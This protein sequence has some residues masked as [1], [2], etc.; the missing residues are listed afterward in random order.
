[1]IRYRT[2]RRGVNELAMVSL[3]SSLAFASPALAQDA[4]TPPEVPPRPFS[5]PG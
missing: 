4:S 3:A 5:P 2:I 1:M